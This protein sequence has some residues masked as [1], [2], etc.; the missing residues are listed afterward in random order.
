[1]IGRALGAASLIAMLG[2]GASGCASKTGDAV[3]PEATACMQDNSRVRARDY[4]ERLRLL[5][6]QASAFAACMS[7]HGF[8]LDEAKL[9]A[10]LRRLAQV[11]NADRLG[12]DPQL[13]LA[14][15]EQELRAMPAFWRRGG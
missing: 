1:V 10:E 15:R 13:E 12:G 7:E 8:V 14:L 2:L 5:R 11:R 9:E 6:Q 4:A 3:P